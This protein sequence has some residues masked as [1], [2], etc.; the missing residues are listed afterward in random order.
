[1][2]NSAKRVLAF[3]MCMVL[4]VSA[5]SVPKADAAVKAK[6]ITLSA[7]KKTLTVGKRFTLKVKRVKPAK[8]KK[9]VIWKSNKKAVA[10]VSKKGVVKAL[11]VGKAKITATSKSNKKVKARCTVTVKK[12]KKVKPGTSSVPSA[13]PTASSPATE[14]ATPMPSPTASPTLRPSP[15]PTIAPSPTASPIVIPEDCPY[16]DYEAR[17]M[18]ATNNYGTPIIDGE[19]DEVWGTIEEWM[20]PN[21][22][23]TG[24][25]GGSTA[26]VWD[27]PMYKVLWDDHHVYVLVK[28]HDTDLDASNPEVYLQDSIEVFLSETNSKLQYEEEVSVGYLDTDY[29]YRVNYMGEQSYDSNSPEEKFTS[30]VTSLDDGYLVEMSIETT[31]ELTNGID[32]GF[33]LQHNVCKD[34]DREYQWNFFD[35]FNSAWESTVSFGTLLLGGKPE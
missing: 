12:A 31:R 8:A 17:T 11:K 34:G 2:R 22:T 23:N 3:A 15:S 14:S 30:A 33:E 1:M 19:I 16:V 25:N 26:E 7:T 35:D 21:K 28:V 20:Q 13:V 29:H 6:K 18:D 24:Y 10:S 5:I 32:I 4:A 9:A 27:Y